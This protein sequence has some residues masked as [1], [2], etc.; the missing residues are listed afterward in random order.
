MDVADDPSAAMADTNFD[1]GARGRFWTKAR[2]TVNGVDEKISTA[3]KRKRM[4][5]PV[6]KKEIRSREAGVH[7]DGASCRSSIRRNLERSRS[8]ERICLCFKKPNKAVINAKTQNDD[9]KKT[10]PA[11]FRSW[12]KS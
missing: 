9:K 8:V 10:G 6:L 4:E 7:R 12:V 11:A 2:T 1:E 3:K 5:V